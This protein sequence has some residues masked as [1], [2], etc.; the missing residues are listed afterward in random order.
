MRVPQGFFADDETVLSER[1]QSYLKGTLAWELTVHRGQL[2]E[3]CASHESH[4]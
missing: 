2:E 3:E 4:A 1:L